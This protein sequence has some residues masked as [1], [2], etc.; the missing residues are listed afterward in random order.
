MKGADKSDV[1][2]R[3]HVL[4]AYTKFLQ[5]TDQRASESAAM[6]FTDTIACSGGSELGNVSSQDLYML[7]TG[8]RR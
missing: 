2:E 6:N 5:R 3:L 8:R 7:L 1:V 4:C